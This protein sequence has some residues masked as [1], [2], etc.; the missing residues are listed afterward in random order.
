MSKTYA[1]IY[2]PAEPV[3][4]PLPDP[5]ESQRNK[6]SL[7]QAFR[8][9]SGN[10]RMR[11]DEIWSNM[12]LTS[13]TAFTQRYAVGAITNIVN[14]Q[15]VTNKTMLDSLFNTYAPALNLT[16]SQMGYNSL[17]E[18]RTAVSGANINPSNFVQGFADGLAAVQSLSNKEDYSRYGEEIPIDVVT[19]L[20][21]TYESRVASQKIEQDGFLSE[22]A[23]GLDPVSVEVSGNIKNENAELWGINDINQKIVDIQHKKQKITF[24]VG[25]SIY[26]NCTINSYKPTI[27]NIYDIPFKMNVVFDYRL[28]SSSVANGS[29]RVMNPERL[30]GDFDRLPTICAKEVYGGIISGKNSDSYA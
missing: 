7:T 28:N 21:Y 27:T 3:K 23:T 5:V 2:V 12:S 15:P 1:A 14:G 16:A 22:Y 18:L 25:K 26:E 17:M 10:I 6:N 9:L 4:K 8:R 20:I 13:A 29:Y 11:A 19:K 24:R 30:I